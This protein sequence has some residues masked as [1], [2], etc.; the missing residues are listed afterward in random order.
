MFK[1]VEEYYNENRRKHLKRLTFKL[2]TEQAAEDVVQEAFY[3]ACKYIQSYSG[4][5]PFGKWFSRILT[6]ASIDYINSER[7]Y[8]GGMSDE[9]ESYSCPS[10]N[11]QIRREISELI[12]TKS[13][14]QIEV[15]TLYFVY[16]Y[17][18]K[19]VAAVT[20]Y[21]YAQCHQIIQRFRTELKELYKE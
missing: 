1:V 6:N 20:Q 15:L 3:R 17:S 12:E 21:S 5:E 4:L 19:D 13:V 14:V 11:E 2:G 16:E 18:A 7:N 8:D 9:E 10:F